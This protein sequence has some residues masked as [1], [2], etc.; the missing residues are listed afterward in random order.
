M[1]K[2]NMTKCIINL[3]I[4]NKSIQME[5]YTGSALSSIS[6]NDY[7]QLHFQQN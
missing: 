5:L 3:Q 4:E 7:K 1:G 6:L 2:Q